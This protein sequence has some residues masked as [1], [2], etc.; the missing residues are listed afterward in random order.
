MDK[1][2]LEQFK[3]EH[4]LD[5]LIA[6]NKHLLT[7]KFPELSID[8]IVLQVERIVDDRIHKIFD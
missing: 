2:I 8:E 5:L 7:S 6:E 3:R 1:D 4:T